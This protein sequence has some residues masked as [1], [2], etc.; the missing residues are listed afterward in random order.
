MIFKIDADYIEL[1]IVTPFK[2][3]EIYEYVTTKEGLKKDAMLGKDSFK[4]STTGTEFLSIKQLR[5]FRKNV[6]LKYHLRPSYIF[7]KLTDK[8]LTLKLLLN[9][10]KYGLR[11]LKNVV[12]F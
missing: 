11:L 8:N 1:S 12:S 2:G 3:T 10:T 7:K 6:I 4:I 5:N 9:Y